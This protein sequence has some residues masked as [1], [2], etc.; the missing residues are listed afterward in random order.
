[1]PTC[2][3]RSCLN[4]DHFII[5]DILLL[6]DRLTKLVQTPFLKPSPM[7]HPPQLILHLSV[8]KKNL[9]PI[10]SLGLSPAFA[11]DFA[12]TSA[13]ELTESIV[14]KHPS[15]WSTRLRDYK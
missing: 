15:L 8:V 3:S 7:F 2:R 4:L 9:N 12:A 11:F 13:T 14:T 5:S 10:L 1:V 6:L